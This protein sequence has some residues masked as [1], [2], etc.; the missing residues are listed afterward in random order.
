VGVAKSTGAKRTEV[1]EK[2]VEI[3]VLARGYY[4]RLFFGEADLLRPD[5]ARGDPAEDRLVSLGCDLVMYKVVRLRK[6]GLGREVDT[7]VSVML[8]R[9]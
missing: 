7:S 1:P 3:A 8:A 6:L 5:L 4:T 2:A 9:S